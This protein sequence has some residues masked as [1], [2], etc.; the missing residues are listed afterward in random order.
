[1]C[2]FSRQLSGPAADVLAKGRQSIEAHGGSLDGDTQRGTIR[3]PT[4][5][6]EVAG[7]YTISGTTIAFHVTVKPFFVPCFTI[8]ATVDR[9]LFG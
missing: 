5:V 2:D 8:E 3:L 9:Y 4:P 6:G 7:D 1:M